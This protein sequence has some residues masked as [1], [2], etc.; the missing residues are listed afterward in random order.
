MSK[1]SSLIFETMPQLLLL[2]VEMW[3]KDEELL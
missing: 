3:V 2:L 1:L